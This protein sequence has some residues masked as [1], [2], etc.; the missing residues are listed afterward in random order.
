MLSIICYIF[1]YFYLICGCYITVI[2]LIMFFSRTVAEGLTEK[3]HRS[4]QWEL[5]C[6][7]REIKKLKFILIMYTE[8]FLPK[9]RIRSVWALL[10]CIH[11]Q[12]FCNIS[13]LINY[14]SNLYLKIYTFFIFSIC[15]FD[16]I[17]G[18]ICAS[19]CLVIVFLYIYFCIISYCIVFLIL[20]I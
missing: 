19:F 3:H 4:R 8:I 11:L 1:F 10:I 7:K 5:V 16:I 17:F 14:K 15:I 12:S 18:T 2:N 13:G 20:S 9:S 6:V